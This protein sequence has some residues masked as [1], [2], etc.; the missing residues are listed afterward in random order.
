MTP[1]SHRPRMSLRGAILI[2]A[3]VL[4][5]VASIGFGMLRTHAPDP[6]ALGASSGATNAEAPAPLVLPEHP[7]ILVFGDSWT[8]GSA[9]TPPTDGYAYRLADLMHGTT[10]VDGV[11]GSGYLKPG[12]D[13]PAYGPRIDRLDPALRPDLVVIEGSINDRRL[14]A[15]D[16]RAAVDAAWNRLADIYPDAGIVV[17]GPAPQ[18]LPVEQATAR[19]DHDLQQLAAQRGWWYISPVQQKW[20]TPQNYTGLIDTG[21]GRDHP[22]NAG[23][24]YLAEKVAAALKE[25]AGAPVTVA[26]E[27]AETVQPVAP[28][29]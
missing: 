28:G 6:V 15:T 2:G 23:H 21:P 25:M 5:T 14:P 22:S 1:P 11:R 7:R 17:L 19:I 10:I 12:L 4:V 13:G 27:P 9:A 26:V 20:I 3:A 18:V 29:K 24:R 16:Y 8:Y